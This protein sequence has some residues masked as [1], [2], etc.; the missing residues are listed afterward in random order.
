MKKLKNKFILSVLILLFFENV[1]ASDRLAPDFE[2]PYL[3]GKKSLKLSEVLFQKDFTIL[4]FFNSKC[5][6]C[7]DT[8]ARLKEL[9]LLM[10][11]SNISAQIIGINNDTENTNKIKS[12]IKGEQ[13]DFPILMDKLGTA[14]NA[15]SCSDY[16]FSSF[17]IDKKGII[18]DIHFDKDPKIIDYLLEKLIEAL[19]K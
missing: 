16:S 11:N 7:M 15:Y 12:F 6:E 14:T 2:L 19:P 5:D 9:P 8:F 18:K 10:Q 13:I 17:I 3:K 4:V 1:Y